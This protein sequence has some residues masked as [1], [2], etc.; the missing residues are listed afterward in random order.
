MMFAPFICDSCDPMIPL[1]QGMLNERVFAKVT[2][3][4]S[5]EAQELRGGHHVA[6]FFWGVSFV[7]TKNG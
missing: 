3:T 1:S 7:R 6:L 2:M 4:T 5:S